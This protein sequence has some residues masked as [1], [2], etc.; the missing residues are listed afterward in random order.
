MEQIALK[1]TEQ[2]FA[3]TLTEEVS[4][5]MLVSD[6]PEKRAEAVRKLLEML[7][8]NEEDYKDPELQAKISTL[9]EQYN[10]NAQ[11]QETKIDFKLM[12]VQ[13]LQQQNPALKRRVTMHKK[14]ENQQAQDRELRELEQQ[15]I[16]EIKK[17]NA[18]EL[19]RQIS[20]IHQ[21]TKL[22][23]EK[24]KAEKELRKSKRMSTRGIRPVLA[25]ALASKA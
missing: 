18:E 7:G 25:N 2:Q 15:R 9:L 11:I 17:K 19:Q 10:P 4:P 16:E 8:M 1:N 5:D 3:Q 23:K 13:G 14:K 24:M 20:M 12:A 6:D 21:E 22:A